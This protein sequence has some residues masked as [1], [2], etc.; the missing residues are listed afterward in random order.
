[1]RTTLFAHGFED[2][3]FGTDPETGYAWTATLGSPSCQ[4]SVKHHG[5]YAMLCS[6]TG[7]GCYRSGLA[8]YDTFHARIFVRFSSLPPSDGTARACWVLQLRNA[9]GTAI[10]RVQFS[11]SAA[12]LLR[13]QMVSAFP[14]LHEEV[15]LYNWEIDTWYMIEL[16]Y[17]NSATVGEYRTY[18]N[19]AEVME[20]TGQDT[21]GGG[22]CDQIRTGAIVITAG[23][24][25]NVYTDCVKGADVYIGLEGVAYTETI[26]EILGMVDTVAPRTDFKQSITDILGMLDSVVAPGTLHLTISDIIGMLDSVTAPG[27]LH[28]II[29]D[30]L[31]LLDSI[32]LRGDF[33]QSIS[34][35]LGLLDSIAKKAGYHV[36]ITEILAQKDTMLVIRVRP[37]IRVLTPTR[38]IAPTRVQE[39]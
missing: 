17:V 24:T 6:A 3:A 14:A 5:T 13:L 28:A 22:Q 25:V 20:Y 18:L 2:C 30:S 11:R 31:G 38:V 23:W 34:E 7:T 29:T 16:K 35:I 1:M 12:G 33:K 4:S 26:S 10:V 37:V 39:V 15:Y 21:S 36:T 19:N 32:S 9:A 8:G 27:T